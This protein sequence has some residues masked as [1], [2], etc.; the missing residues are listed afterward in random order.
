MSQ[1]EYLERLVH[2]RL[3][4]NK[5]RDMQQSLSKRIIF[6]KM[7]N[8]FE[9]LFDFKATSTEVLDT[10]YS[11]TMELKVQALEMVS[12][13]LPGPNLWRFT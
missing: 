1:K 10:L 8:E 12:A 9:L 13:T 3:G 4:N 5:F 7:A 2:C 11:E 6:Y